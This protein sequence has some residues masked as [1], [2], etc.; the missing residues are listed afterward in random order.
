[1]FDETA[2]SLS[3]VVFSTNG[4]QVV[5]SIAPDWDIVTTGNGSF[6]VYRQAITDTTAPGNP[7]YA[8][9]IV[10][11]SGYSQPLILRQRILAPRIFS[12][13]MVSGTF[14][15]EAHSGGPYTL[16]MSYVPSGTLTPQTICTG[17]TPITSFGL[18]FNNTAVTITTGAAGAAPTAYVDITITIPVG[19]D[20]QI[21]CIQLA[22]VSSSTEIVNYLQNTPEEEI[23]GLFH[24]YKP[25]LDYKPIS[26]YLV[27]W[28][29]ALNP[30]QFGFSG[31]LGAL[32][33]NTG[34]Y[35]WDQTILFQSTTNTISYAS[36]TYDGL[37][38]SATGNT[39]LAMIQYLELS[40][41][42]NMVNSNLSSLVR[43]SVSAPITFTI[44][45]WVTDNAAVPVLPT[46]LI[47]TLDAN[48]HPSAVVS[49]WNEI[50]NAYGNATFTAT[51]GSYTDFGF[52]GWLA[53]QIPSTTNNFAIVIGTSALVNTNAL[54]FHSVS[55]VPGDIPTI[56]APQTVDQVL[57]ECEYYYEKSYTDNV[58]PGS[59]SDTANEIVVSMESVSV[60]ANANAFSY[61]TPF[62]WVF[63]NK[64]R[65]P[66]LV[67]IYDPV[68]GTV[69]N[70][71]STLYYAYTGTGAFTATTPASQIQASWWDFANGNK[72][73]HFTPK[74]VNPLSS[75]NTSSSTNVF[76]S[77]SIVFHYRLD[78]RLGV[79]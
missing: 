74:N 13:A 60:L 18:I 36:G 9:G 59:T 53:A 48:G 46:T 70:V 52:S 61:A 3:P 10:A 8:L 40:T 14:I 43:L 25:E 50:K 21:S 73:I 76:S 55:L 17:A 34:G 27:G 42:L 19:A 64:K 66:P 24:Y 33:A 32:G 35:A 63:R 79:I 77:A 78:S 31:S 71:L 45:L 57:S 5:T 4:T 47:T 41:V 38:I 65:V 22:G 11:S 2:T 28:D 29:F 1:M 72:S 49:G 39:Q 26:S 67:T 68:N 16:T 20:I 6:S 12:G 37:S 62:G 69:G 15:A 44:S 30:A 23:N 54:E 58:I 56:P 75:T 7:A 51:A